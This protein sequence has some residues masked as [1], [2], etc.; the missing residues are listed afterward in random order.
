MLT[1]YGM[2][3][4]EFFIS[5]QPYFSFKILRFPYLCNFRNS[6]LGSA[7]FWRGHGSFYLQNQDQLSA[8]SVLRFE[9]NPAKTYPT[10]WKRFGTQAFGDVTFDWRDYW[11]ENTSNMAGPGVI[12]C[13]IRCLCPPIS[14]NTRVKF[15]KITSAFFR[16]QHTRPV[17]DD[18]VK[19]VS[20]AHRENSPCAGLKRIVD[21]LLYGVWI[22]QSDAI[23]EMRL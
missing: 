12:K 4:S 17:E 14:S 20:T 15:C 16:R 18:R 9:R 5:W 3:L 22:V 13:S 11:R 8:K 7:R 2:F 10:Y 6:V 1:R 23:W 19:N 21:L